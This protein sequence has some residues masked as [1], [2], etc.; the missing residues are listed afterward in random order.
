MSTCE[1]VRVKQY[2]V[3]YPVLFWANRYIR[4][5]LTQESAIMAGSEQKNLQNLCLQMLSQVLSVFSFL[6][7]TLIFKKN[8]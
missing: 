5:T 6:C 4:Q 1:N 2:I 8:F 3:T 7:K